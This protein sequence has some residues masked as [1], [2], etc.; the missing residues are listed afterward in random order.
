MVWSWKVPSYCDIPQ[1][2]SAR[3]SFGV[4]LTVSAARVR[5]VAH[6]LLEAGWHHRLDIRRLATVQA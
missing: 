1:I 4:I 3:S 5:L 6:V 2:M